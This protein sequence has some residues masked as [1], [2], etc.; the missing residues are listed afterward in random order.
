MQCLSSL[1]MSLRAYSL[2]MNI[3]TTNLNKVTILTKDKGRKQFF[4]SIKL[5]IWVTHASSQIATMFKLLVILYF[6]YINTI[7]R[8]LYF[9]VLIMNL[10]LFRLL[11]V[12]IVEKEHFKRFLL[13]CLR[14]KWITWQR[15]NC[16]SCLVLVVI[17]LGLWG[18]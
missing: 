8:D 17:S 18:A 10:F 9:D 15:G 12:R 7:S 13:V 2:M 14:G 5:H 6:Y 3:I 1:K 11:Q 4:L 16:V